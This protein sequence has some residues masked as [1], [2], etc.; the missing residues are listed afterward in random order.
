MLGVPG[1]V[2]VTYPP[3]S[4]ETLYFFWGV[5]LPNIFGLLPFLERGPHNVFGEGGNNSKVPGSQEI[6]TLRE[7]PKESESKLS[8]VATSGE[9]KL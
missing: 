4:F 2:G 8:T 3:E 1:N 9:N 5:D 6:K 7:A